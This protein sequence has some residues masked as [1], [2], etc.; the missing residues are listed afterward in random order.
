[1]NRKNWPRAYGPGLIFPF[2]D[3]S[4]AV[5]LN[6]VKPDHPPTKGGKAAKYLQPSGAPIRA[7]IP[8]GLN[9][10]LQNPERIGL[11]TEGEKKT[12]AGVQA[13]FVTV[14]LIGVDCWHP[15]KSSALLPDLERLR[16]T[17][18]RCSSRS[19]PTAR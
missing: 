19:I 10:E 17:A 3:D 18:G 8:P 1:M 9:G 7:Y 12:Q 2:H 15:R 13:G 4:G 5:V 16:G 14:G 11:L 6:R